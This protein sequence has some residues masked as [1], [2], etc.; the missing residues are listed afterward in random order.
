MTL[1]RKMWDRNLLPG[2]EGQALVRASG[3]LGPGLWTSF[4][5]AGKVEKCE[6]VSGLRLFVERCAEGCLE[7]NWGL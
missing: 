7:Q 6:P 2:A 1:E 4:I 3:C 5:P